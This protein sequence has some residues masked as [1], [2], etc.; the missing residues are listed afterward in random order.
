MLLYRPVGAV[1]LKLIAESGFRSFP[2][3][4]PHQPI[5]YPVVSEDYADRIAREWNTKDE[6]SGFAGFVSAF[7]VPDSVAVRY[8]PRAVGGSDWQELWVPAGE[9]A[10]FNDLIEGG[11]RIGAAYYGEGF[12]GVVDRI[13]GLPMWAARAPRINGCPWVTARVTFLTADVLG[14][15]ASSLDLTSGE[16]IPHIVIESPEVRTAA[17]GPTGALQAIY[18]RVRVFG[19]RECKLGV[20]VTVSMDLKMPGPPYADV[21]PGA[22]FIIHE[23]RTI[24]GHGQVLSRVDP[25]G[26]R[27][28]TPPG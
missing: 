21:I 8:P 26:T 28:A 1:E 11:I 5:F 22:T 7:S 12:A 16:Y 19:P 25:P 2:P 6:A 24:V 4:R 3:R 20:P 13:G 23:G 17:D 14:H 15:Q 18:T 10:R 9:L 27:S